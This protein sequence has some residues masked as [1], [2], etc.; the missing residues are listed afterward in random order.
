LLVSH[1][2]PLGHTRFQ[3][4]VCAGHPHRR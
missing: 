1:H 3:R 2:E 4:L